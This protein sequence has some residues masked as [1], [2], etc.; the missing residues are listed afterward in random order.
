MLNLLAATGH[1]NYAKSANDGYTNLKDTE[2]CIY[3]C[4][5]EKSYHTVRRSDRYWVGLWADG[6]KE[7]MMMRLLKTKVA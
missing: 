6:K 4:F 7:Q 2:P 1:L 3:K 5:K